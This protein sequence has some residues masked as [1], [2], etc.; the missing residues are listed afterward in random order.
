MSQSRQPVP[1]SDASHVCCDPNK[2]LE[3]VL[4]PGFYWYSPYLIFHLN[5]DHSL[6][7]Q[8]FYEKTPD[9][10]VKVENHLVLALHL[11]RL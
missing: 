7:M 2:L 6:G 8:G 11:P 4:F 1:D 3:G 5:E 9:E 10:G